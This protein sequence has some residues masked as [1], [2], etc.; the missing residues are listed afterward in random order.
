LGYFFKKALLIEDCDDI[1]DFYRSFF[2]IEELP[3]EIMTTIPQ[4]EIDMSQYDVVICDWFVGS[5][6]AEKW[7]RHLNDKNQLP[8]AT[9]VATGL[10]EA[11]DIINDLPIHLIF[12]P[13]AFYRLKDFLVDI[14]ATNP[15]SSRKLNLGDVKLTELKPLMAISV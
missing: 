5:S 4:D 9:V 15:I 7:L 1:C 2:E 10:L 8:V 6:S 11:E 13:F 3:L 14:V 12:K